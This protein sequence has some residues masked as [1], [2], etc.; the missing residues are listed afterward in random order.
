MIYVKFTLSQNA[1]SSLNIAIEHF[2]KFY[3]SDDSKSLNES[4]MNEEIKI[5]LVFLENSIELLLKVILVTIDETCIYKCPESKRIKKAQARVNDEN[6][7]ADILLQDGSFRTIDYYEVVDKYIKLTG[8]TSKKVEIALKQLSYARN[9]ITHFGIEIASYDE[10]VLLFFNTFDVIYNYLYDHLCSLNDID[11]FFTSDD[12]IVKTIHGY[13][14]LFS[15]NFIYNNILDILDEILVDNNEYIFKL[16]ANNEKTKILEFTNVFAETIKDKKF[17]DLLDKH[18]AKISLRENDILSNEY[19]FNIDINESISSE[20]LSR[21]SPFYNAT[22][23]TDDS[24]EIV[25]IVAH[26][27]GAVYSY[28]NNVIYPD[29]D[30]REKDMQWIED[31]QNKN[32]IKYNLSKKG[33]IKVFEN[34]IIKLKKEFE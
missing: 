31:Q 14:P 23:F 3:Y 22:I 25:F 27:E 28:I 9:S 12:V 10:I 21:Y 34:F 11:D 6:T 1:I 17:E 7:L 4:E 2:K 13:K 8:E 24:G 32:C 29:M 16:R 19:F 33:L 5:A 20:V 18:N 30:V 26:T 15:E